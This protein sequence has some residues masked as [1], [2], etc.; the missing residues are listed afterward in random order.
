MQDTEIFAGS[1]V[2][3][4]YQID[5]GKSLYHSDIPVVRRADIGKHCGTFAES[6]VAQNPIQFVQGL[7]GEGWGVWSQFLECTQVVVLESQQVVWKISVLRHHEVIVELHVLV[8]IFRLFYDVDN[9]III[10][11]VIFTVYCECFLQIHLRFYQFSEPRIGIKGLEVAEVESLGQHQQ[12]E[13]NHEGSQAIVGSHFLDV[14]KT[15]CKYQR[16]INPYSISKEPVAY[17][18]GNNDT[19]GGNPMRCSQ[20]CCGRRIV[21]HLLYLLEKHSGGSEQLGA[22]TEHTGTTCYCQ[23]AAKPVVVVK[24]ETYQ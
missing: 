3:A 7:D 9:L 24:T 11:E 13:R 16:S 20:T 23:N 12:E 2:V 5:F 4:L 6:H 14:G 8:W 10:T 22:D 19:E 21:V 15:S 1:S 17:E 18:Y